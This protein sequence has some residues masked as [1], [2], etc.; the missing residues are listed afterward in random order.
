MN[1][2]GKV[3]PGKGTVEDHGD[4]TIIGNATPRFCYG[5]NLAIGYRGF[6]VSALLQGVGKRDF[7]M[8]GSTYLFGGRNYF[9]HHLDHFS[10]ARPDGWLPRLTDGTGSGDADWKVNTGYNT[11]RYLL[12][13]A[14]MRMKNLMVSY[15]FGDGLIEKM[16]LKGL[17]IYASCDNV[18]MPSIRRPSILSTPGQEEAVPQRR[19]SHPLWFRT[20][21][22]RSILSQE[23]LFV[24]SI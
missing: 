14:Y 6:E 18:P 3:N 13:A 7:P 9:T 15:T 21:M 23:P 20:E 22:P 11:S 1:N 16:R 2:D 8:A 10:S 19:D 5:I 17:R 12:N 4:L 24:E